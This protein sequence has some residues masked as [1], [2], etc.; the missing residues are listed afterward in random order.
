MAVITESA[1][2]AMYTE[3]KTSFSRRPI[4]DRVIVREIPL[5][6]YYEQSSDVNLP[7][8]N[9]HIK[10]RSDRGIVVSVS[11]TA[12]EE[13]AVGDTVFFDEL[14]LND[15]IYLNPADRNRHDL[16]KYWLIRVG[17]LKGVQVA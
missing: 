10:I 7:L 3:R 4:L 6:D 16:P 15:P 5:E 13:V 2:N 1:L 12:G 8:D 14:A 17:D 11:R 9:K